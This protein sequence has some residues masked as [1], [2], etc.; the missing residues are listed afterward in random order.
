MKAKKNKFITA[1]W[2]LYY[3]FFIFVSNEKNFGRSITQSCENRM[4][5][6]WNSDYLFRRFVFGSD[7]MHSEKWPVL[8]D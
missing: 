3:I 8:T 6:K 7:K 2:V 4:N 5:N 1:F